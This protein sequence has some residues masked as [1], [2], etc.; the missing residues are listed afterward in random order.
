MARAWPHACMVTEIDRPKE[1]RSCRLPR[2][3]AVKQALLESLT[4]LSPPLDLLASNASIGGSCSYHPTR[5]QGMA[6]HW[7]TDRTLYNVVTN[8]QD[9]TA[10]AKLYV[11]PLFVKQR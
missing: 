2:C 9:S 10:Q 4:S 6:Y 3:A 5:I 1:I 11:A 8:L 7:S